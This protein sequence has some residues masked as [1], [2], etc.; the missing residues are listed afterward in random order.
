MSHLELFLLFSWEMIENLCTYYC[1]YMLGKWIAHKFFKPK[2][3]PK[4]DVT[5]D[6]RAW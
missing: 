6:E 3:E 2:S 5:E 1:M 4:P